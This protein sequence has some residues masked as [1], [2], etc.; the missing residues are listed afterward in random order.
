MVF[1]AAVGPVVEISAGSIRFLTVYLLGGI[2]GV[3]AHL[4][5]TQGLKNPTPLIG[6]SGCISGC[7]AYY[8]Y[9]YYHV[10]VN[11][12]PKVSVPVIAIIG[13]WVVLQV[14]GAFVNIGANQGGT[15][16]WA[17]LGGFAMGIILSLT[18]G[19]PRQAIIELS[20]HAV[21]E[22]GER[23]PAAKLA[24]ANQLLRTLPNDPAGLWQKA[25]ALGQLDEPEEEGACLL[26]FL[27][28][29]DE[30][31]KPDALIR[32]DKI[33]RLNLI[34]SRRRTR[35][36]DDYKAE[37]PDLSRLLLLSVVHDLSDDE[38][39]DALYAL[40]C[41]DQDSYPDT[42]KSWIKELFGTYPLHPAADLARAKGWAP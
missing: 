21:V 28:F 29:A 24:A 14:A 6:A 34:S 15:A 41:L 20:R 7:I 37:L 4:V 42:A 27:E 25:D 33:S 11:L 38:R 17:H 2:A 35:L 1:L 12:A 8:A 40:A 13:F 5:F 10:K 3:L 18:F 30:G 19:A 36:A 9:R 26:K 32:L 23:S 22:M 39:P 16:Y 31:D